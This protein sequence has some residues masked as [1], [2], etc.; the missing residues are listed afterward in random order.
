NHYGT[1]DLG[2][3]AHETPE[4]VMIR[5]HLV[6]N[7][8]LSLIFPESKRQPTFAQYNPEL[9]YFESSNSNLYCTAYGGIPLVRYDLKDY[10]GVLTR[11]EVHDKLAQ[12]GFDVTA[13]ARAAGI[14]KLL[15]NLP[16]VYVYERNDFSISYYAF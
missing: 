2:T 3:M 7:N 12:S 11:T 1:V 15:W 6:K 13:Q 4:S 9:F 5:R 14:D 10:G 8:S 16:Y